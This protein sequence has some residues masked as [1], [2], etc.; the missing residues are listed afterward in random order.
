LVYRI[1]HAI[2]AK[3][4]IT[5]LAPWFQMNVAGPLGKRVLQQPVHNLHDGAFV[6]AQLAA[7]TQFQE[8]L[9]I[10]NPG[11]RFHRALER[12]AHRARDAVKLQS[13]SG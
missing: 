13:D 5:L 2:N 11:R 1:Q 8:L 12:A 4:D 3:S 9:E 10:E 6:G 7:A